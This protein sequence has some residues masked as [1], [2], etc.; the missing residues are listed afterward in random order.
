MDGPINIE[1]GTN[2]IE[3][4][5]EVLAKSREERNIKSGKYLFLSL[6]FPPPTLYL[7]LF[8]AWR[9]RHL[10]VV[11]PFLTF[12]F[13]IFVFLIGVVGLFPAKVP[14]QYTQEYSTIESNPVSLAIKILLF[15]T[16]VLSVIG[17]VFGFAFWR[18]AKTKNTLDN[19]L[20]WILFGVL[21]V[22][23]ISG[24]YL[25]YWLVMKI[26]STVAPIVN[27]GYTGL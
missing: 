2:T 21:S 22:E 9:S 16:I 18:R 4:F 10:Y 23:I 17:I 14:A 6:L 5:D 12:I 26:Y 24:I 19:K 25:L 1:S 11:L 20:I 8:F 13:S 27:S 3:Q 7:A 15:F